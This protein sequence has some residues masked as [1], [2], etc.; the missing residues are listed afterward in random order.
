VAKVLVQMYFT[1]NSK[2]KSCH[3]DTFR[4]RSPSRNAT[5]ASPFTQQRGF[6]LLE[7]LVVVSIVLIMTSVIVLGFT[8]ADTNTRIKTEAQR[9]ALLVE[10]ARSES[11]QSNR[12]WGLYIEEPEYRFAALDPIT[13]TWNAI[14]QR[15]FRNR[16]L[17]NNITLRLS[18]NTRDDEFDSIILPGTDIAEGVASEQPDIVIFS[19]GELTPFKINVQVDEEFAVWVVQSDGLSRAK[20]E[21][22]SRDR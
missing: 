1:R 12:E 16:I 15:N 7:I 4:A 20:A 3:S 5:T 18:R 17:T 19:D 2:L 6:T 9:L 10:L 8:G 14:D 21:Q 22:V 13:G 11:M